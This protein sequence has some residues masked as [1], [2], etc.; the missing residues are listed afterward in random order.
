MVCEDEPLL[1]ADL[2]DKL[3]AKGFYVVGPFGIQRDA[4]RALEL[5][6]V[7]GVILDVELA[8]GASTRLA[9]L[10]QD[11]GIPFIVVSG[12]TTPA[13]PPEFANVEW[14][15]KPAEMSRVF[16]FC[17]GVGRL[18]PA[19]PPSLRRPWEGSRPTP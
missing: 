9:G 12:L 19:T 1:A 16:A 4:I 3:Q 8:D 10:L 18:S 5:E 13:P 17:D 15:L 14:L 6:P 11:G 2:C 7:D